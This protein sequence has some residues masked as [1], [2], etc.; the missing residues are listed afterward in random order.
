MNFIKKIVDGKV[1]ES[2]HGQFQK[3]SKGEFR[4]RALIKAKNSKGKYT[5]T[6]GAEFA[7]E[8][9]KNVAEKLGNEKTKVTGG[10][11]STINLKEIP[12]YNHLLAQAKVKQFQGVKNYSIDVE[13]SGNEIIKIVDAFPKAFFALS[14]SLPNGE[15]T[16]KIKPKAPKSAKSKSN[17]DEKPNPDFCKLKTN[18]KKLGESFIFEKPDFKEA[19]IN[20]TYFIE[21][22]VV[23]SELKNEKDFAKVREMAR[24]KGRIVRDAEIDGENLKKE[25]KFEA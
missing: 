15:T 7:N 22:I 21:E 8:L 6:T 13:M 17:S 9:V 20:H 1:D 19:Q 12:E 24:R 10:I 14:F 23:P 18:D 3:F 25:I 2:V 4:N 5:I 11:I 16:L